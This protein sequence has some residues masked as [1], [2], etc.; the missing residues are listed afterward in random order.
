MTTIYCW[1]CEK[2]LGQVS[3]G[4]EAEEAPKLRENL[5]GKCPYCKRDLWPNTQ[6]RAKRVN[7]LSMRMF[8]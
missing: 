1:G 4:K 5:G 8:T 6:Q 2:P 7:A 3:T